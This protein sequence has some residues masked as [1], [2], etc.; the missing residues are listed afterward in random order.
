MTWTKVAEQFCKGLVVLAVS[1]VSAACVTQAKLVP[2]NE[3]TPGTDVGWAK[4]PPPTGSAWYAPDSPKESAIYVK[5]L[6]SPKHTF[7]AT[8]ITQTVSN[9]CANSE[10]LLAHVRV[11]QE[12]NRQDKRYRFISQEAEITNWDGFACISH[13]MVAI[14]QGSPHFPGEKLNFFQKGISCLRPGTSGEVIDLTYSERNGPSEGS[15]ALVMEGESFLKGL[16]R[17]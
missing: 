10:E 17:R 5:K 15:P 12:Q 2:V 14:D 1:I 13:R 4:V 3:S 6:E 8:V 16:K 9:C 7:V 11:V